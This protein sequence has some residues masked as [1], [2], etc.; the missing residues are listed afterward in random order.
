MLKLQEKGYKDELPVFAFLFEM[1]RSCNDPW[2]GGEIMS[3]KRK[4]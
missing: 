3:R 1:L 2:M 4:F